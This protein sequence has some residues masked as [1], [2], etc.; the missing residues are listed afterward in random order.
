MSDGIDVRTEGGV[1]RITFDRPERLNALDAAMGD[2]L[3]TELERVP[4]RDE[5]RV[6]VLAGAGGAFCA[7]VDVTG[8]EPLDHRAVDAA[9]RIIRAVLAADRPVVAAVGGVAAGVGC[10]IA[11]ACDLV[12]ATASASFVLAFARIGLMPDGGATATLAAS[13]GRARAMR[14]ALLGESMSAGE[15][16]ANG[17]V[18]HLVADADF[19]SS[20]ADVVGRVAV[21]APLA[22][23]ATKKA[24]N[25]ATLG[26]LEEALARE[27]AGQSVLLGT[28]DAAEGIRAFAEKRKP[29]F[30]G[31]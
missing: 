16:Y 8:E 27:R 29:T 30:R 28:D 7:G 22:Q 17:L 24:V 10:S 23:A 6:V 21:G 15:A 25:A 31:S 13:L 11:L 26:H 1:L 14:L 12:V 5:V 3:A 18:S 4:A 19:E 9:N 20:V 2:R